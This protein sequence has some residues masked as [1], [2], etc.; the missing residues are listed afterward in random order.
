MIQNIV[1]LKFNRE[2]KEEY[3][4]VSILTEEGI[5]EDGSLLIVPYSKKKPTVALEYKSDIYIAIFDN[6]DLKIKYFVQ[7]RV[8][9]KHGEW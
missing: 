3:T 8:G 5:T 9:V 7:R 2:K 4:N 6:K 1:A